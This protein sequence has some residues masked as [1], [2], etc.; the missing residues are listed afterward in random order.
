MDGGRQNEEKGKCAVKKRVILFC[1]AALLVAGTIIGGSLA[2]ISAIGSLATNEMNAANLRVDVENT[3][4]IDTD[5]VM[6]GDTI[7]P[8]STQFSIK[9][10]ADTPA[11]I[12]LIIKKYWISENSES[13]DAAFTKDMNLSPALISLSVP[14]E[15]FIHAIGGMAVSS[16]ETD[17][18]YCKAPCDAGETI[19]LPLVLSVDHNVDNT[20]KGAKI[21]L[22]V[23]VDAVQYVQGETELNQNGILST[24]GV[25]AELSEDG[26]IIS[27]AE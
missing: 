5:V 7:D 6:P 16:N 13:S 11:Y 19:T 3:Y 21:E 18:L 24:F 8:E 27:L 26:E 20:Y 14:D 15:S 4:I 9:N 25:M 17:V 12:R 22:S 23:S 2:S 1:M 10:T